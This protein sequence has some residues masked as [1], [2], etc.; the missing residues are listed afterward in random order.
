MKIAVIYARYSSDNQTEQS[1][2]GQLRVCEQY[3]QNNGYAILRKYIDRAMTGTN[4]NR[5]DFQRMIKDSSNKEF[6]YII[7]YKIDRFSRNKYEIAKNKKILK[8]NGV[9]LVS[10]MENIPDTPEGIIL[11]SLLEGM[12][13]YYSAEL[14]QK[15]KRGMNET[16]LKGNFTGGKLIYGYKVKDHKIIVNE[17]EAKVVRYIFQ[18]YILG[19]FAKDIVDSLTD[20]GI[21]NK[22]KP[23]TTSM[24]YKMLQNEKYFG[25]FRHGN[26]IFKNIYPKIIS[27]DTYEKVRKLCLKN[28]YGKRSLEVTYLLR[29][30][31][32]CGYCGETISGESGTGKGGTKSRYYKC[33]GRKKHNGCKK[34]MIRKEPFE[35][36]ITDNVVKLLRKPD[37]MELVIENVLKA[38]N[39]VSEDVTL[40][41]SLMKERDDAQK[42]L[43]NVMKAI[44]AGII[45]NTTNNRIKELENTIN[46]LNARIVIENGKITAEKVSEE[47]I[48]KFYKEALH[49]E[50][51]T[52]INYVIKNIKV[53]NDKIEIIL[54]APIETSPVNNQQGVFIYSYSTSFKHCDTQNHI[55]P[56]NSNFKVKIYV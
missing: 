37:I 35:K 10:A 31:L 36:F 16:R 6:E 53:Y 43:N 49:Y 46:D 32:T 56:Y 3:A 29:H 30:K 48:R 14:S 28:K 33:F 4:D 41:K 8:D 18:Q 17:K 34:T 23:F 26:E 19:S 52:L 24:I 12:A 5:P 22:T 15:V 47:D 13:E 27:K 54:N 2:E 51:S 21:L 39:K 50:Q 45:N 25:I 9:K 44:E 40:L 1:I 42:A 20:K 38:Q 7:V 55:N 11:E